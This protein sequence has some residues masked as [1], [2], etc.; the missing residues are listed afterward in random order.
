[1]IAVSLVFL[2]HTHGDV[3]L[4]LQSIL[5]GSMDGSIYEVLIDHSGKDR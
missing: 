3:A 2:Y 5:L 4:A 1:M